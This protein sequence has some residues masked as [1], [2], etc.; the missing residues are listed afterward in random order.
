MKSLLLHV[1]YTMDPDRVK[2]SKPPDE[3]VDPDLNTEEWEPTF[4]KVDNPGR[5]SSFSYRPL[6]TYVSQSN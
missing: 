6:F 2:V 1:E 3:W 4:D 5:W